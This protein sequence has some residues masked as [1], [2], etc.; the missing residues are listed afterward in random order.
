MQEE[1]EEASGP[2]G[3]TPSTVVIGS[4]SE[5]E[6]QSWGRPG[7]PT[8]AEEEG[9][10]EEPGSSIRAP[11]QQEEDNKPSVSGPSRGPLQLEDLELPAAL[12]GRLYGHQVGRTSKT[13]SSPPS[14]ADVSLWRC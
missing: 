2:P 11:Q 8:G 7:V 14:A 4:D 10:D 13:P 3:G 1:E 5:E 12:H 6:E 9:V